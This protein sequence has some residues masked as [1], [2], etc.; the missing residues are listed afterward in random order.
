MEIVSNANKD[1]TTIVA[2][3]CTQRDT[4]KRENYLNILNQ[5]G[6]KFIFD[7]DYNVKKLYIGIQTVHN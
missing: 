1:K 7:G 5:L 2:I 6:N 4:Q 3:Y